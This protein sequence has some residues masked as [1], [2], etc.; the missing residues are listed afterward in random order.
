M[1]KEF[2]Y[3]K[4]NQRQVFSIADHGAVPQY[5]NRRKPNGSSFTA[6]LDGQPTFRPPFQDVTKTHMTASVKSFVNKG[7]LGKVFTVFAVVSFMV[8]C[9]GMFVTI[10]SL[11]NGGK[12]GATSQESQAVGA[13]AGVG[14]GIVTLTPTVTEE[15]PKSTPFPTAT[16]KSLSNPISSRSQRSA[17]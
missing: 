16:P 7:G 10:T 9:A 4:R 1:A 14:V 13:M 8:I 6:P 11:G 17:R 15:P 2:G 5:A 12:G 3:E